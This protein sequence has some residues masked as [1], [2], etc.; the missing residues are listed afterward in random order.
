[1]LVQN[2]DEKIHYPG[3]P[4]YD[5]LTSKSKVFSHILDENKTTKRIASASRNLRISTA[6][7]NKTPSIRP[8]TS[9]SKSILRSQPDILKPYSITPGANREKQSLNKTVDSQ[10]K[11][12]MD[13]KE[14]VF[15]FIRTKKYFRLHSK[16]LIHLRINF[17]EEERKLVMQE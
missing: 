11:Y 15:I 17:A 7:S 2:M 3:N 9:Q 8:V 6:I 14:V 1:M 4:F 12:N 16:K 5:A 13:S 10:E